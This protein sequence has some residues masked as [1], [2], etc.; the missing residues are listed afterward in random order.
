M[1]KASGCE[2][3]AVGKFGRLFGAGSGS[4]TEQE[5]AAIG[6]PGGPMHD[7]DGTSPD[8][9]IPAGYIF[10]A[11]FIDHDITLDTTSNFR[12]DPQSVTV[13][14]LPNIRSASLDLDCIYGFGPEA[15]PHIYDANRPG[16]IALHP[17]GYDLARD[18]GGRAL[19][20][21]PRNDEN[22]FVAQMQ[23]LFQ[24]FHNKIY[25]ERV[26]R[27]PGSKHLDR[28]EE[29]QKQTR[30]HYQWL[31]LFDFLKRLC[32]PCVYKHAVPKILT[33][34]PKQYPYFQHPDNCGKL[35]M[36]VEF[37]V[38]AYRVGH[39]MVRSR[40]AANAHE[41]DIE[42]FDERFGTLGFNGIPEEL[43]VDWR[44]LL[45][46]HRCIR[47]R[48]AKGIDPKLA[49]EIQDMP[50]PV[51]NSRNP[52]DRAL[53]FRNLMRGNVMRL[54]SGQQVAAA[55]QQKYGDCLQEFDLG[56]DVLPCGCDIDAEK[57]AGDTPLF[58]YILRESEIRHKCE[59]LGPVGSAI[60]LEVFGGM[61]VHCENTFIHE[62]SWHPDPCVSKERWGWWTT[63][64]KEEF[65]K[66]ELIN[67]PDYYPFDLADVVRFVNGL[68]DPQA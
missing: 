18:L 12:D 47:P 40:Y 57:I 4:L 3:V 29:A 30:Y 23:L 53:G 45:P 21:D 17:N 33:G 32:D 15:S 7:F 31:V 63:E 28:F 8:S 37:S 55:L 5:A 26:E 9:G 48:M 59:R 61:L 41:L 39:T 54:P 68:P 62:E 64:Y 20:G 10:F 1:S 24:R 2:H 43:V 11:Q 6:G 52:N 44:Y 50:L 49:D 38:A 34:D 35:R 42:L 60:L 51:V 66:H 58:Y 67:E 56:L 25:E 46:V 65:S 19:I 16:H 27:D 22:I 36:P 13:E 14:D